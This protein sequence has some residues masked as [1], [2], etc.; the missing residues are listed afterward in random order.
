MKLKLKILSS[1]FCI[2]LILM[3]YLPRTQADS[4][5]ISP[6]TIYGTTVTFSVSY[7][8]FHF[9]ESS[10]ISLAITVNFYNETISAVNIT[11][12]HARL[13]YSGANMSQKAGYPAPTLQDSYAYAD[14]LS[15]DYYGSS[16]YPSSTPFP[17]RIER[18]SSEV[19]T[20]HWDLPLTLSYMS[21]MQHEV[22]AKLYVQITL[23]FLDL[24]GEPIWRVAE[25]PHF[26]ESGYHW[27]LFSDEGEAPYVTVLPKTVSEFWLFRL[28][29][30]AL[31]VGLIALILTLVVFFK[32]RRK[33]T[34]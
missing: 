30:L 4:F 14:W 27:V 22:Q 19:A 7:S 29:I 1:L 5:L 25:F 13:Y 28:D 16:S 9:D 17:H 11:S 32:A 15:T 2:Y 21:S 24:N 23:C 12:I 18:A 31:I 3:L 20:G 33:T 10:N 34:I 6:Q 26:W 8:D